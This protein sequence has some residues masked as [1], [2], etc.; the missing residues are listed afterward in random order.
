[1]RSCRV[2]P[3]L[4]P[5]YLAQWSLFFASYLS[6]I[7]SSLLSIISPISLDPIELSRTRNIFRVTQVNCTIF[8]NCDFPNRRKSSN[9]C[10]HRVTWSVDTILVPKFHGGDNNVP[11]LDACYVL[12]GCWL[13]IDWQRIGVVFSNMLANFGSNE[14]ILGYLASKG[15]WRYPIN[16]ESKKE[17]EWRN[18]KLLWIYSDS[19]AW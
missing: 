5:R 15:T 2:S 6:S 16:R 4:P 14:S 12:V 3:R 1:M 13:I 9:V 17:A 11:L 10:I 8:R 18:R 7:H 19:T